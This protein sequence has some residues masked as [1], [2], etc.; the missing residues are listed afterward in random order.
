MKFNTIMAI[1]RYNK[2]RV[3]KGMATHRKVC[4]ISIQDECLLEV[5]D[6]VM[7]IRG[8]LTDNKS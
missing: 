8:L 1:L 5:Y 6:A 3:I 2:M 4:D 7:A